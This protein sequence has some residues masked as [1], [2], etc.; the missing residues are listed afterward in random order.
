MPVLK[1]ET[2]VNGQRMYVAVPFD[3]AQYPPDMREP[4]RRQVEEYARRSLSE[5][6]LARIDIVWT[7]D[8]GPIGSCK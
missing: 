1:A 2:D 8:S 7:E 6:I 3:L 5:A 4:Y